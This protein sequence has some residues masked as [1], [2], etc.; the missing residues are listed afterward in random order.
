MQGAK[1]QGLEDACQV[2]AIGARDTKVCP[3]S[4]PQ[5]QVGEQMVEA[6]VAQDVVEMIPQGL[7]GLALDLI[8]VSDDSIEPVV[9]VEPLGG[10]LGAHARNP[11][12]VVT[13]LPHEGSKMRVALGRHPV[14]HLDLFRRH[15]AQ[16]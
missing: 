5:V 10:G 16:R 11:G 9:E 12:E 6:S 13:G 3:G 4:D 7:P 15:P 14:A 8:G 1:L 2:T